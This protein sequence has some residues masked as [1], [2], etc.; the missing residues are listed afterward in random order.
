MGLP[1]TDLRTDGSEVGGRP[2]SGPR[3]PRANC[4]SSRGRQTTP[5]ARTSNAIDVPYWYGRR[6][7]HMNAGRGNR[8]LELATPWFHARRKHTRIRPRGRTP[9]R[10]ARSLL[11]LEAAAGTL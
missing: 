10:K 9:S 4:R 11:A 3:R 2:A 8:A 7:N 1:V 5:R 6:L